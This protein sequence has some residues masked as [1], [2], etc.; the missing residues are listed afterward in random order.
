[1]SQPAPY[2]SYTFRDYLDLEAAANVKHEFFNGEIYAM[3][4]GTP[5]HAALIM[6]IGAALVTQLRGGT[7]R[8][9][10]SD[11]R[12]RVLATGLATYPDVTVVCGELRTDPGS[13]LIAVNPKI[14]IEV[15]SD[16]TASYDRGEKLEQYKQ[17]ESLHAVLLFSQTSRRVELHERTE[18]GFRTEVITDEQRVLL[19]SIGAE[20]SLA[21]VY[22]DAGL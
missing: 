5:E 22:S 20:L 9:F 15:L 13:A 14:L 11:L 12:V 21:S 2:H 10:S 16:S 8:V 4:G 7:C 19:P 18:R 1:V 6:A 17:I 3:A